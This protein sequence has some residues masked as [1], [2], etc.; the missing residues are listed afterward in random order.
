MLV[1]L[2]GVLELSKQYNKVYTIAHIPLL[3]VIIEKDRVRYRYQ[4]AVT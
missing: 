4:V 3:S 1:V 2:G